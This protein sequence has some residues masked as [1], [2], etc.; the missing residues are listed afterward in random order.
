MHVS[1]Y[2]MIGGVVLLAVVLYANR[3]CTSCKDKLS[4]LTGSAG[5]TGAFPGAGSGV[6]VSSAYTH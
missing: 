2:A 4:H 1:H 3:N 6:R 5:G